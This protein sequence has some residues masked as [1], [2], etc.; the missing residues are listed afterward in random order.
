VPGQEGIVL[1]VL[2]WNLFHGRDFPPDPALRT[3]RSRLLRLSE[4]NATHVQV[5]RPLLD[6]FAGWLE[7]SSWRVALLQEAPPRWFPALAGR[8]GAHGA[9]ALTSRN[10]GACA[11]RRLADFNPDLIASNEGGSNQLLLRP[12]GRIG[13]VRRLTL[14]LLPERRRMLFSRLALGQGRHLCVANLHASAG[15]PRAAAAEVERA[16]EAAVQWA[17]ADPLVFGGDLNLRPRA[18]PEVFE[19]LRDRFGLAPPTGADAIDHLLARGLET[20]E[21]PARLPPERREVPGLEGLRIRLSDHAPVI[22]AF[23]MK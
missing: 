5:N 17:G 23:G 4:R 7:Q 11:R 15:R 8:A 19:R 1:T 9:I 16:A 20:V 13:E 12:P 2:S 10:L 3:W 6:E 21:P 22:A 18:D 14:T